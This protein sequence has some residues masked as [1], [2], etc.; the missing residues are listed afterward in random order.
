MPRLK[1]DEVATG[2][3][4]GTGTGADAASVLMLFV[5]I[6]L[7]LPS[8]FVFGPLGGAG[9]PAVLF[10]LSCL[11]WWIL[12]RLHRTDRRTSSPVVGAL[13]VFVAALLASYLSAMTRPISAEEVSV[14]TLTLVGA[15]AWFGA[16]LL[17]H[18]G[19]VSTQRLVSLLQFLVVVGAILAAFGVVQ[20]VTGRSWVDELVIPGLQAHQTIGDAAT[21][22]GFT[23]PAGTSIHPIE[24]GSL[25]TMILP[26]ALARGVGQLPRPDGTRAGLFAR[27]WPAALIGIA[28][29]LSL[30]RS[31]LV[32]LA[33]GVLVLALTWT[34]WQRLGL[35]VGLV[36]MFAV[37]FLTVPG[38]I[39]TLLGLFT[40]I[41]SG[42]TSVASRVASYGVAEEYFRQRP[43]FGRGIG[44]FLPSYRIF[45]NQY[46]L[47]LVEIGVVGVTALLALAGS[48]AW[49]AKRA[50][51]G[52]TDPRLRGAA[53]AVGA[54]AVTG[55]VSLALFDGFSFPMMPGLWFL[56]LG[57]CGACYRLSREPVAGP[58]ASTDA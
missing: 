47:S 40:G 58:A 43:A 42:D 10:G 20:F 2:A 15:G 52:S 1:P 19:I 27:W 54:A 50:Y 57:L 8:Q 31:A 9:S 7:S 14:S 44:T 32:G 25:M 3:A 16:M 56:L 22:E 26:L 24:Y 53:A 46:L 21:R 11:A 4:A 49:S 37:V 34:A 6:R 28:I 51:S 55:S 23:R 38:M 30:S 29:V 13:L 35:L 45:D 18:D 5:I 39:G 12:A 36:A 41:S 17:A 33:V 48:A